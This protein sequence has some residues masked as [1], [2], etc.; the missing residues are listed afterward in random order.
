MKVLESFSLEGKVAVVTGGGGLYGKQIAIALSE[1]GATTYIT[2]RNADNLVALEEQFASW[3][4]KVT[5]CQLDQQDESSIFR[6]RD[7]IIE[8]TGRIDVLVNNAV[9]RTMK[10]WDDSAAAF[11]ESME[12]NATGLFMI[13]RAFGNLM[14]KQGGGSILNIGSI[15]GMIG[16]DVGLYDDLN[17]HSLIPDYFFHKGGMINFTRFVASYYGSKQ[18][19]CNCISPGGLNAEISDG[20]FVKRY[21]ANTM[22]GRMANHT[23]LKGSI[24]F[25]A[26]DASVYITGANLPVD[27]GYTAK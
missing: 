21:S 18:V 23:D 8:D 20:T 19:R 11:A 14:A 26:S 16:P 5:A 10:S 25:L 1:A 4:C 27:G 7:R 15:Q 3:G 12:I 2:S 24:V 17:F 22:L 6:L 9:A 13:T